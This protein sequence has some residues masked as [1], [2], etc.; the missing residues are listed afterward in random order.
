MQVQPTFSAAFTRSL[1]DAM[2]NLGVPRQNLLKASGLSI[3]QMD[4]PD[5]RIPASRHEAIY[6]YA[7]Q[8]LGDEDK[9][10]IEAAIHRQPDAYNVVGY[11]FHKSPNL[12]TAIGDVIQYFAIISDVYDFYLE[13]DQEVSY[14]CGKPNPYGY[15]PHPLIHVCALASWVGAFRWLMGQDFVP[16]EVSFSHDAPLNLTAYETY[17]R[18]PLT[19]SQDRWRLVLDTETLHTPLPGH[20]DGLTSLLKHQARKLVQQHIQIK[21]DYQYKVEQILSGGLH[22]G[23]ANIVSV[24]RQ[25]NISQRTL[26]RYLHDEGVSYAE[27]LDKVRLQLALQHIHNPHI[28]LGEIAYLLGY[29][30]TVP[31]HRTFKRWTGIAPGKYRQKEKIST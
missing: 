24:A 17:F 8:W 13:V 6:Q 19:F 29:S 16:L 15:R 18:C 5:R 28:S 22:A 7:A 14:L 30:S 11:I 3:E 20:D 27:L 10:W 23:R 1:I 31:F 26:Q 12:R 9:V 25:L 4:D 21:G 2:T